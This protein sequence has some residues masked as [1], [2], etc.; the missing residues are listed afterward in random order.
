M[1]LQHLRAVV[2]A[3]RAEYEAGGRLGE[4]DRQ[5]DHFRAEGRW[6]FDE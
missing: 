4:F 1:W 3:L 2:E 6:P 5:V